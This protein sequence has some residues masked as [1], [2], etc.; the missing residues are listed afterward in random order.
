MAVLTIADPVRNQVDDFTDLKAKV[1]VNNVEIEATPTPPVADDFMYDF[2]YNHELPTIGKMGVVEVPST[3][4]A[5]DEATMLL[6][7]L[8]KVMGN[9]DAAEFADLFL[10]CGKFSAIPGDLYTELNA[11]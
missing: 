10:D 4:D 6:T 5:R 7:R 11:F 1:V 9:G 2:K 3:C 8:S